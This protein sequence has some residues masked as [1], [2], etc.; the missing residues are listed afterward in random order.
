MVTL[1]VLLSHSSP[2]SKIVLVIFVVEHLTASPFHNVLRPRLGMLLPSG[3][4]S[5][6]RAEIDDGGKYKDERGIIPHSTR[7]SQLQQQTTTRI[8]VPGT[9]SC[10]EGPVR[11]E[12]TSDTGTW[13]KQEL[14]RWLNGSH[15]STMSSRTTPKSNLW[16]L[17]KW[18]AGLSRWPPRNSQRSLC[19]SWTTF[20]SGPMIR[21]GCK[22]A[23]SFMT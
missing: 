16:L 15:K 17:H 12:L 19:I 2:F 18:P 11:M 6:W 22:V 9:R 10:T 7:R 3:H 1:N 21:Q 13:S 20:C 14:Q 5:A 4:A 23:L 8:E